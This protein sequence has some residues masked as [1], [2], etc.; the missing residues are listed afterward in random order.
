[1]VLSDPVLASMLRAGDKVRLANGE[2]RVI[3]RVWAEGSTIWLDGGLV[4]P[5]D[6]SSGNIIDLIVP[7][8]VY[9]EYA[10]SL[11]HRAFAVSDFQ[12]IPVSWGRSEK[13]LRSKMT[14][15][16]SL[17]GLSPTTSHV[18]SFNGSH[19]IEGDDPQLSFDISA[20]SVS[21]RNSGL[22]K[23]DFNCIEK[24]SESRVQIFWWGDERDGPF[25][26]S[27]VRFTAENGTLIVPLD[28]SSWWLGLRQVKGLRFDLD[29][30]S[31]CR[32]FSVENISL[33]RR[34]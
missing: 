29:N 20:L 14:M 10:A 18:S 5:T 2:I 22:L 30:A 4:A 32:A 34:E 8:D 25:E 27:S 17:T 3:E 21:G 15:P 16:V 7:P 31:A 24:T 33:Y 1:M 26:A 12:K 6:I 19:K 13:S 11:F 23:F 9:Q 28:A